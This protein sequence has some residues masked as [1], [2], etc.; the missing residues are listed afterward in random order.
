[1][2][3]V[4]HIVKT[5]GARA[6]ADRLGVTRSAVSNAAMANQFPASWYL[7]VCDLCDEHDMGEPP[8]SL[9]GFKRGYEE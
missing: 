1:M 6:I 5:L 7:V 8:Y 2:T 4:K 3:D 9:F